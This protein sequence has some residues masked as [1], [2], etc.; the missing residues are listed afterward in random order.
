[1]Q[2]AMC[3]QEK[4]IDHPVHDSVGNSILNTWSIFTGLLYVKLAWTEDHDEF[5]GTTSA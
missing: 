3:I 1:M 4:S 2:Q 5:W